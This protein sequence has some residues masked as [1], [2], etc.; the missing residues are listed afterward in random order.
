MICTL[1]ASSI[2]LSVGDGSMAVLIP[3][4][5]SVRIFNETGTNGETA[6]VHLYGETKIQLPGVSAEQVI[7]ALRNCAERGE[8][9]H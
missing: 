1:I 7:E 8:S 3:E 5:Q 6:V 2:L 9:S 4:D